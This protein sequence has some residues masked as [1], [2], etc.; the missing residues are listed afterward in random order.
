MGEER[1]NMKKLLILGALLPLLALAL[2]VIT[3]SPEATAASKKKDKKESSSLYSYAAQEG[4]TYSQIARKAVQTYGIRENVKLTPAEII[5]VE[6]NL[7]QQAGSPML[8]VGQKVA[9]EKSSIKDWVKKAEKLNEEEQAAW[10]V[11]VPYVNFNTNA[12]G[13][14]PKTN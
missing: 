1:V 5:F 6:T 13:Q 8:E 7:T 12:V 10:Q 14:A 9:L 11:Y 2:A 4:D 3:P